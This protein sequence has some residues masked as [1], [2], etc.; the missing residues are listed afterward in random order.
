MINQHRSSLNGIQAHFTSKNDTN[1]ESKVRQ[2]IVLSE[3]D[4]FAAGKFRTGIKFWMD[5]SEKCF[6]QTLQHPSS[7]RIGFCHRKCRFS[8]WKPKICNYF[9][10]SSMKCYRQY[11][12]TY[13]N[14]AGDISGVLDIWQERKCEWETINYRQCDCIWKALASSKLLVLMVFGMCKL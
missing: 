8:G 5:R 10:C 7:M 3:H 14:N 11:Q 2:P 6:A 1:S 4:R 9:I 13:W 12:I